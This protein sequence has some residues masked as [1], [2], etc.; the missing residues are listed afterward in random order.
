MNHVKNWTLHTDAFLASL[1]KKKPTQISKT[2]VNTK[3]LKDKLESDIQFL[4]AKIDQIKKNKSPN[5]VMQKNYRQM[6]KSRLDVI[7]W[8]GNHS[9]NGQLA[10]QI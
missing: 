4:E 8:L 6:L 1:N 10:D 3:I 5:S 7:R 9:D 2:G